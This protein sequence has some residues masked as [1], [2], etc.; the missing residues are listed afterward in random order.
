MAS[1]CS[2]YYDEF[3]ENHKTKYLASSC[4]VLDSNLGFTLYSQIDVLPF[5]PP[6]RGDIKVNFFLDNDFQDRK[7]HDLTDY[8]CALA[9]NIFMQNVCDLF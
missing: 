3:R 8:I 7:F 4:L 9:K 1:V 2:L 6:N 5:F